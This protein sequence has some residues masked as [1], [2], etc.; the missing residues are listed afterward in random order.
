MPITR[1]EADIEIQEHI[2]RIFLIEIPNIILG[3]LDGLIMIFS[4]V[5]KRIIPSLLR[6]P[7]ILPK[8]LFFLLSCIDLVIN[9][10]WWAHSHYAIYRDNRKNGLNNDS[11]WDTLKKIPWYNHFITFIINGLINVA[12]FFALFLRGTFGLASPMMFMVAL[13][14]ACILGIMN[15]AKTIRS[16]LKKNSDRHQSPDEQALSQKKTLWILGVTATL[17]AKTIAI[18]FLL[19][20]SPAYMG[21]LIIGMVLAS[22]SASRLILRFLNPHASIKTIVSPYP[23]NPDVVEIEDRPAPMYQVAFEAF[24]SSINH[25]TPP[26]IWI[27]EVPFNLTYKPLP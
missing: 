11:F 20:S 10:I 21:M 26:F 17:I 1:I 8:S 4:A 19:F 2:N 6:I 9:M 22:T 23:E 13:T 14:L 16:Y 7:A 5:F 3:T 12:D 27:P 18:G 24:R 25:E 15:S